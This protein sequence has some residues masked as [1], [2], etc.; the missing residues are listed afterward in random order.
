MMNMNS[1][2]YGFTSAQRRILNRYSTFL[3]SLYP[4]FDRISLMFE[5]R[6]KNGHQLASLPKDSRLVNAPFNERYLKTFWG[7]TR[8]TLLLGEAFFSDLEIFTRECLEMTGK[9]SR[10]EPID[11]VDFRQFSLS[12]SPTWMLFPPTKVPDLIHEL[13]LR[14]DELR[15]AVG[16]LK[17]TLGEVYVESFGL[18]SV[19]TTAME[20]RSCNCHATPKVAQA[21]FGEPVTTPVWDFNYSSRDPSVSAE[22]YKADIA[23]LFTGF[24][25]V[26]AQMQLFI[27]ELYRRIHGLFIE[28]LRAKTAARLGE[29]NF[30]L[31]GTLEGA[32]ECVKMMNHLELWLRE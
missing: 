31:A 21:L 14:F 8:E 20:Y 11:L 17:F 5:H 2:D 30:K 6:R 16:E 19:F 28:L 22:E 13:A 23:A 7:R 4:T 1:Q 10:D 32:G 9:T 18:R 3:G 25:A 12:R 27:E 26:I 15:I 29:L 24:V